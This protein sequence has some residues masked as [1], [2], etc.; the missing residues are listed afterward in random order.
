MKVSD[1]NVLTSCT[2]DELHE[3][4]ID[5]YCEHIFPAV[6]YLLLKPCRGQISLQRIE[7]VPT[8]Y[9]GKVEEILGLF[10]CFLDG[11]TTFT[12]PYK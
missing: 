10:P 7:T 2:K 4:F 11:N 9:V 8:P 12:I 1:F 3:R 6:V 5:L